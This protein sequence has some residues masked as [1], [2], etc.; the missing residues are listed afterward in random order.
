LN[1]DKRGR[2]VG[3]FDGDDQ[4]LAITK[5]GT[6]K[7][8]NYELTNRYEPEKT[9]LVEKF[10]PKKAISAIYVDGESK[11]YIVKRFLIETNTLDKEF[12]FISEG[13]GS[14]LEFA[15]TSDTPEVEVEMVKGKGK[16]KETEIINLEDIIDVKGW[17]AMGNRLSQFKVTKVKP[18]DEPEDASSEDG[19]EG[20]E[21]T[22]SKATGTGKGTES[23]KKKYSNEEDFTIAETSES[24]EPE[25]I[26]EDDGQAALFGEPKQKDQGPL[27]NG[28]PPKAKGPK[29]KEAEQANLFGESKKEEVKS[30]KKEAEETEEKKPEKKTFTS[31]DSIEFDL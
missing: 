17:K 13:I 7:I 20:D 14:R 8:T 22:T 27:V 30:K 4:I 23:P 9:I 16:D 3:K 19:E 2:Y 21:E 18:L 1:K 28:K 10:N 24:I 25:I 5:S 15:T 12:L 29:P 11:Q 26:I 6:Y 31:G